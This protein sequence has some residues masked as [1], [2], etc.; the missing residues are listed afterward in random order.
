MKITYDKE[1]DALYLG[2]ARGKVKKTVPVNSRVIV[3]IGEKGKV[4][5]VEL[6]FVSEKMPKK[7]LHSDLV[8]SQVM[9]R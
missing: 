7:S 8:K 2:T 6:L 5:G 3:D 9:A 1:A 4:V